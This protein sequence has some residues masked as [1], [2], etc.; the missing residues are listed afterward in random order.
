[1]KTGDV[2]GMESL[3]M[4]RGILGILRLIVLWVGGNAMRRGILRLIVLWVGGNTMRRGILRLIVLWVG[5]NA[6]RRGILRVFALAVVLAFSYSSFAVNLIQCRGNAQQHYNEYKPVYE[7][8]PGNVQK[9]YAMSVRAIC[10][11]KMQE[12]MTLL[13]K[14][15]DGGHVQANYYMGVYYEKGQSFD[16]SKPVTEDPKH[17]NAMLFYFNRVADLIESNPQYP[18]GTTEDMPEFEEKNRISAK[19]FVILPDLYFSGYSRALGKIL[20]SAEKTEYTDTLEVLRKM[21]DSADRCL[22]RPA[23]AI[24]KHNRGETSHIMQVRC[25]ATLDFAEGALPLEQER[26]SVARQCV[27]PLNECPEH[28]TIMNT[29]IGLSKIRVDKLNS[30]PSL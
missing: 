6:M 16:L 13:E 14:S 29:L 26:L 8:D 21:R 12:G 11:N 3:G 30:V 4:M 27:M 22:R 15:A 25:G 5:G 28:Q 18:E 17:F 24:W 1:M 7:K 9:I 20:W 19:V 10:V 23:L 2:T